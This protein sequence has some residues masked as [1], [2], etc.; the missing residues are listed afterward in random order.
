MR[1]VGSLRT[2]RASSGARTDPTALRFLVGNEL[3]AARETA[4]MTQME[5]AA[6]LGC[7]QPKINYLETGKTSQ[8]PDDV[9]T[10][11]R[12]YNAETARVDRI[13]SLAGRA[14]QGTWWASFTDV[15]PDWFRTFVGLEGLAAEEFAFGSLL[16][17]GQLQT[18]DYATALFV[19]SFQTAEF[20]IPQ[21]VRARMARQ[22]LTNEE[23][24]LKFHAVLEQNTIERTVG[25]REVMRHQLEHLLL[26]MERD[27]VSIQ[28]MPTEVSVHAGMQGDFLLLFFEEAQSIGYIEYVSGAIY[29][30]DSSE[31]LRYATVA[32]RISADALSEA[33]TKIVIE[34]RIAELDN[35][36]TE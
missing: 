12:A 36:L 25:S 18:A 19:G 23:H 22:R 7:R 15:L 27:N 13:A 32:E 17:P 20:E 11:L 2:Q 35:N 16:F 29:V 21:V 28:V 26:L 4:G 24:P 5:A 34:R 3:R 1:V 8:K 6:V 10:L 14:D 30:Q 33:D 31:V 9:T